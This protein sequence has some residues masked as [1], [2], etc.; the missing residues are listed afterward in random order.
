M[1]DHMKHILILIFTVLLSGQVYAGYKTV[2]EA[3]AP[4]A[5]QSNTGTMTGQE[6]SYYN[7]DNADSVQT[8]QSSTQRQYQYESNAK[9]CRTLNGVWL[10]IGE[11]G[12]AAC[13]DNSETMKKE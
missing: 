9:Q 12:Y 5:D 6:K 7:Y 13:M 2:S 1:E 11:R 3:A 4:S 8:G 10:S